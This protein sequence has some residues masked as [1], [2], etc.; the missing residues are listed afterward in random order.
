[1]FSD[2]TET[3]TAIADAATKLFSEKGY[4]ET[5]M[6]G[7]AKKAGITSA[8]IYNHFNSKKELFDY[9][10]ETFTNAV[11][12]SYKCFPEEL[13]RLIENPTA[14]NF[15]NCFKVSF[16]PSDSMKFMNG[17]CL[18]IKEQHRQEFARQFIEK[19]FIRNYERTSADILTIL[20]DK[21]I[22]RNDINIDFWVKTQS[23]IMYAFAN[24]LF[25]GIGDDAPDFEGLKTE[26]LIREMFNLILSL[27]KY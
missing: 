19:Y 20:I 26:G 5:N 9:I 8:S 18:I 27:Y 13:D 4:A 12:S 23:S 22:L 6:R 15:A 24:R 2:H 25:L 16:S 1:V 3:K 11:S 7:I 21:G 14:E 10:V 17:L